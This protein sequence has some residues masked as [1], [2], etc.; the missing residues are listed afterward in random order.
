MEDCRRL[1]GSTE[2]VRSSIRYELLPFSRYLCC[3]L[4]PQWAD[5]KAKGVDNKMSKRNFVV[6]IEEC[7]RHTFPF[8]RFFHPLS[9]FSILLF[10]YWIDFLSSILNFCYFFRRCRR[11]DSISISSRCFFNGTS[12]NIFSFSLLF[13]VHGVSILIIHDIALQHFDVDEILGKLS[14]FFPSSVAR[15]RRFVLWAV[16]YHL[17]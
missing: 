9:K 14:F 8:L 13:I 10:F 3:V 17:P 7:T 16:H 2:R 1:P 11:H 4:A 15:F 12:S 5:R 6:G